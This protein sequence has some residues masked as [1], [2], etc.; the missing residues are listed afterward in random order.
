[1]VG[2]GISAHE[3]SNT[4]MTSLRRMQIND[5][6]KEKEE[7]AKKGPPFHFKGGMAN[8]HGCTKFQSIKLLLPTIETSCVK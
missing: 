8:S 5:K 6:Y 2:V 4:R 1:M 3:T 7:L